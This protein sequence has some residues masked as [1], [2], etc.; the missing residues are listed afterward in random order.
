M[1]KLI[2]SAIACGAVLSL[3][4]CSSEEPAIAEKGDGNV[5]FTLELPSGIAT[6]AF[7][8]GTSALNLSYAV[9]EH[10]SKTPII[11]SK[12]E[13]KFNNLRAMVSLNLV[14]G[15][16]YDIIWWA[17]NEA[18]PYDFK[19]DEQ[20]V[21][22]SYDGIAVNQE[23]R[24]AFFNTTTTGTVTGPINQTVQLRRPFAQVNVGTSDLAEPAVTAAFGTGLTSLNTSIK[25]KA[26]QT[27]NLISGEATDETEVTFAAG[28]VPSGETFPVAGFDYLSMD[29]LLMTSS[30]EIQDMAIE[31]YNGTALYNTVNVSNVP[32]QR[33]YRTNI[34]GQLLTS[35]SD[36]NVEI[37]PDFETPD[38][39]VTFK[40]T[41]AAEL[42]EALG[43]PTA[44]EIQIDQ[45]LDASTLV[46]EDFNL[47]TPKKIVIADNATLTMPASAYFT[48]S[49]DLTIQGGT[50]TNDGTTTRSAGSEPAADGSKGLFRIYG[51]NFTIDGTTVVNDIDYHYHGTGFNSAAI[52]YWNDANITIINSTVKSGEFTICGMGR[53]VAS[54]VVTLKDSYFE[55]T[56]SSTNNGKNWAYAMRLFGSTG[57]IDNCTVKGIQG[58]VSAEEINL[59]INSGLFYTVNTPGK[60]DA[61]YPLY[62]TNGGRVTINGGYFYGAMKRSN[63]EG[64]DGNSCVVSGDNDV[65]LPLGSVILKGGYFNGKAYNHVTN[66]IY[67]PESPFKYEACNVE[68]DGMTFTWTVTK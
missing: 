28:N 10:G 53:G 18:A 14:N 29:Y 40:P 5:N 52:A 31:I 60:T 20:T 59:T 63:I 33:N 68:K 43:S 7:G 48:T 38:Y 49:Q 54:G 9:Y 34:Y 22:V 32:V 1:K 27:L 56:S 3:A 65:N 62:I 50:I 23:N 42:G 57:T 6:R 19:A 26:Y 37:V 55:S 66:E 8:D 64:L 61:F 25:A 58:G 13:V 17:D 51:G 45:N 11:S 16:N 30:Q 36:Y 2:Y 24:D 67:S 44:A 47:N 21:T 15:K 46:P 12:D 41:N 35:T 39:Q 4:S